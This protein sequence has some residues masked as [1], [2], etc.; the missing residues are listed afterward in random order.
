MIWRQQSEAVSTTRTA[1]IASTSSSARTRT[2]DNRRR[3]QIVF[4]WLVVPPDDR[5]R[6]VKDARKAVGNVIGFKQKFGLVVAACYFSKRR[7]RAR[8]GGCTGPTVVFGH[9]MKCENRL[10]NS[11]LAGADGS[12][13]SRCWNANSRVLAFRNARS[14]WPELRNTDSCT[15][16]G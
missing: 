3:G 6:S 4:S 13:M 2:A 5:A 9:I 10:R 14:F 7:K 15:S 12:L 11:S 1:A 8:Q 16:S